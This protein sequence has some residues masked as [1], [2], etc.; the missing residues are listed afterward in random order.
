[1][2][3]PPLAPS[4]ELQLLSPLEQY[5]VNI[6]HMDFHYSLRKGDGATSDRATI[7]VPGFYGIESGY[8]D[9][10]DNLA[11]SGMTTVTLGQPRKHDLWHP[12]LNRL[13]N[14]G[15]I[16]A[17]TV[18]GTMRDLSEQHSITEFD[19]LC[20][21]N[22]GPVG[23]NAAEHVMITKPR[24]NIKVK[25]VTLCASAGVTNDS[26]IG[27]G[28]MVVPHL[29]EELIE[30]RRVLSDTL[31]SS[32]YLTKVVEEIIKYSTC[33]RILSEAVSANR[34]DVKARVERLGK[35]SVATA[36]LFFVAD[37]L[38]RAAEAEKNLTPIVD[39]FSVMDD[40]SLAGHLATWLYPKEVAASY[41]D[42]RAEL[43]A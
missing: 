37:R 16:L 13:M 33:L 39:A 32:D 10:R 34:C 27:V 4:G 42:L 35:A 18:W 9:L 36:G 19:L 20:H 43:A 23:T 12:R 30:N 1:M 5:D 28:P 2:L 11:L 17:K 38:F 6:D 26:G 25:S 15:N 41:L 31:A 7:I 22:G 21:S 24:P 29:C 3:M 14:P 8:A 40:P